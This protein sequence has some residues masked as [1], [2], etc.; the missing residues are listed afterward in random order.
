[1]MTYSELCPE[2]SI[3]LWR[4]ARRS[5]FAQQPLSTSGSPSP[6]IELA[7]LFPQCPVST[8]PNLWEK[9]FEAHKLNRVV[10]YQEVPT[11]SNPIDHFYRQ[12]LIGHLDAPQ[13]AHYHTDE[14]I[15]NDRLLQ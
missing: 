3:Y 9:E 5:V 2:G 12:G 4:Q 14:L 7:F 13:H 11:W 10:V 15:I 6:D 8:V 1:M